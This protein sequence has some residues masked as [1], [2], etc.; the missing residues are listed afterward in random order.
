MGIEMKRTLGL[1]II[2]VT[3]LVSLGGCYVVPLH[4]RTGGYEHHWHDRYYYDRGSRGHDRHWNGRYYHDRGRGGHYH[5]YR[6]GVH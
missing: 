6:H 1:T 5:R 4:Y 2:M 3:M